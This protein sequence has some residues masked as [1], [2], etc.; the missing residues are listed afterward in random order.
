MKTFQNVKMSL[1]HRIYRPFWCH[2]LSGLVL[3]FVLAFL[4][5]TP[6]TNNFRL[7]FQRSHENFMPVA[8]VGSHNQTD[9]LHAM[10]DTT[11]AD[12]LFHRVRVLCWVL[13]TPKNH[14]SKAKHVKAT[15]GKRCNKLIF[16]STQEDKDLPAVALPVIEDRNNLWGKTKEAMRYVHQHYYDK[17]DWFFK[18]D[19]DTYAVMENMRHMLYFQNSTEAIYFGCKFKPLVRQGYMSGGAGY[20]LS[21]EALRRFVKEALPDRTKCKQ[22]NTGA[23]DAEMGKCLEAV[24]VRAGDSRDPDGRHRFVPLFVLDLLIPGYNGRDFC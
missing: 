1:W 20:V 18:A 6:L 5:T 8:N 23:E 21:K 17:A 2:F 16:M 19:D 9:F 7:R 15:W 13:T 10:T 12:S 14:E 4:F 24:G 11:I 3:G 22:D